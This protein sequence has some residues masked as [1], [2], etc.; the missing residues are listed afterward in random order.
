MF[1]DVGN[2]EYSTVVRRDFCIVGHEEMS[3]RLAF[4]FRFAEIAGV[5]LDCHDH[6]SAVE[7][8]YCVFLC[9]K[10]VK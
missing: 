6:L 4:G 5:A 10:V 8:E 2:V 9:G 1:D 3:T 7:G